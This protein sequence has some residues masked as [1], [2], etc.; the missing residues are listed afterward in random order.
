MRYAVLISL[1]TSLL[2]TD[3]SNVFSSDKPAILA[4]QLR[5]G[6][7][8]QPCVRSQ[9]LASIGITEAETRK[10]DNALGPLDELKAANLC[11]G[12]FRVTLT[13]HP[14]EHLTFSGSHRQCSV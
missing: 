11:S 2:G 12:P 4:R 10:K 6:S 1:Q 7:S 14:A 9:F 13:T 5:M 8:E 3:P